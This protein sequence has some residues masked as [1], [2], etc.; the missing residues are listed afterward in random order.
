MKK[1]LINYKLRDC[2]EAVSLLPH[3]SINLI[4]GLKATFHL[5]IS[6]R[7]QRATGKIERIITITGVAGF[8]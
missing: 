7:E 2:G 3:V 8:L 4:L 1:V 6:M 5:T